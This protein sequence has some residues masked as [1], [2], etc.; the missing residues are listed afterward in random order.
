MDKR[1]SIQT[2]IESRR[3]VM[4]T[5]HHR[6]Q[7]LVNTITPVWVREWT[8]LPTQNHPNFKVSIKSVI[9]NNHPSSKEMICKALPLDQIQQTMQVYKVNTFLNLTSQQLNTYNTNICTV[10]LIW[11]QQAEETAFISIMDR[12][13]KAQSRQ[14]SAT[15]QTCRTKTKWDTNP[16][17][18]YTNQLRLISQAV[19]SQEGRQGQTHHL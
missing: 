6:T 5:G 15:W 4:L 8:N 7:S 16:A 12:T 18:K 1:Q 3:V 13:L 17:I 14:D 2:P 9:L 11:I 10:L 19:D